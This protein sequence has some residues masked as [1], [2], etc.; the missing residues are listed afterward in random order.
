MTVDVAAV[1]AA[2]RTDRQA[3]V[4]ATVVTTRGTVSARAGDKAVVTADGR[5]QGWVGGSCAEPAVIRE[6]RRVL[7]DGNP[8]LLH[9]GPPGE[10][11][12]PT[13]GTVVAPVSCASEGTV[14]VFLEPWTPETHL[15]VIGRS[16][17]VRALVAMAR[18][19]DF[20]VTVVELEELAGADAAALGA[21]VVTTLDLAAAGVDA[22]TYV[23]IATMGRYDE[24]AAEAA[25]A[26]D[27]RYVA[28]V[29][30]ARRGATVVEGLR[31]GGM[32]DAA[33]GPPPLPRRRRPR[34]ATPPRRDRRRHPGR[35]R[36]PQGHGETG[37]RTGRRFLDAGDVRGHRPGVR[38]D[39]H[40]RPVDAG[41]GG[42]RHHDLVLLR[43]LPAQVRGVAP[44]SEIDDVLAVLEATGGHGLAVATVVARA[45][46]PTAAR[47][48]G[49]SYRP[50]GTR[51][52]A[53]SPEG[54]SKAT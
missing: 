13:D 28:M 46:P 20:D 47:A 42:R 48:P 54:A 14:Q 7:A 39:G 6:A 40:R 11:P 49:S 18:A 2:L 31:D 45:A 9:L 53:T 17:L 50:T 41:G 33:P 23:V 1:E 36:G 38:D 34:P 35:D 21:P 12:E 16:P 37:G 22:A 15:V 8:V 52:W 10:L 26:T 4:R 3:H 24:D 51:S 30:S 25:L 5:L 29:A 32:S 19:V 27:A 43:R 44:V